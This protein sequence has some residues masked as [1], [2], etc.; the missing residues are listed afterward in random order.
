MLRSRPNVLQWAHLDV[1]P[2]SKRSSCFVEFCSASLSKLF[3]KGAKPLV[4][5]HLCFLFSFF[6][7]PRYP[8]SHP[9]HSDCGSLR[10]L[11]HPALPWR[12][13][14][15]K[16]TDSS[17]LHGLSGQRSNG[18][19]IDAYGS[20]SPLLSTPVGTATLCSVSSFPQSRSASSA[21]S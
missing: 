1:E 7:A 11:D 4:L 2:F 17:M 9:A 5:G 15:R 3:E 12:A 16:F 6:Q 8:R 14:E 21:V 10:T 19:L 18:I 20:C 13:P